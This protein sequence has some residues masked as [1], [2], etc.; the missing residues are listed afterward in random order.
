ME[1]KCKEEQQ[2]VGRERDTKGRT[3]TKEPQDRVDIQER[4]AQ[5]KRAATK[6]ARTEP[7]ET[8]RGRIIRRRKEEKGRSPKL[9]KEP[10]TTPRRN[11][12]RQAR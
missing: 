9:R 2:G 3:Q 1:R 5:L 12:K 7:E 10:A 6:A 8:M 4:R 11:G